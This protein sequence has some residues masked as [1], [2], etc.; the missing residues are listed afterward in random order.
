LRKW[1]ARKKSVR[2]KVNSF[3]L[4]QWITGKD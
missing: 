4:S 1:C 2:K 3:L